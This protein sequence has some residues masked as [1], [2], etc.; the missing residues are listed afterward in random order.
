M[1]TQPK[2]KTQDGVNFDF[3][4][5]VKTRDEHNKSKRRDKEQGINGY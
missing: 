2:A 4:A 1:K 3:E 5:K